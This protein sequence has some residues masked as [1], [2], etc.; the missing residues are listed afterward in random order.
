MSLDPPTYLASLQNNIRQRPIAWDGAVR[1]GSLNDEQLTRIR[2]VDK[3]KRDA[4]KQTVE[5]DLDGYRT[6]FVG[7]TTVPSILQSAAKQQDV[8]QYILVLLSDLADGR[9]LPLI[10][11]R[12]PIPEAAYRLLPEV[13]FQNRLL[14]ILL[15]LLGLVCCSCLTLFILCLKA[16]HSRC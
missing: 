1:A 5:A 15:S 16:D 11:P 9:C 3:S 13:G 6:L 8:V 10:D 7:S 14:C 4:R 2:A 12:L